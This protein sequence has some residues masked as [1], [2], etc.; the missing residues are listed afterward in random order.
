MA[1]VVLLATIELVWVLIKDVTT[2]PVLL[3]E[4]HQL[5]ELFSLFLLVLVGIELLHSVKLYI[6]HHEIH[7]EMVLGVAIIAVARKV[8]T[9]EPKELPAVT[10]LGMA[11][12]VLAL[13]LGYYSIRRSRKEQGDFE[14]ESKE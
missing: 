12:L 7:L 13:A 9:L 10:L 5:L 14:L 2:P 3:L 11:A 4:I 6:I 8:I 1:V